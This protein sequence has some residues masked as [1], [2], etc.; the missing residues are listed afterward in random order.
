M[1]AITRPK[2][3]TTRAVSSAPS[4]RLVLTTNRRTPGDTPAQRTRKPAQAR[5]FVSTALYVRPYA[6]LPHLLRLLPQ[7]LLPQL[8][9]ALVSERTSQ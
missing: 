7:H 3:G 2:N 9:L 8:P 6:F 4:A 5:G 1:S